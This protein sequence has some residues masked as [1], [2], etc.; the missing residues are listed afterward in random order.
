MTFLSL[1]NFLKLEFLNLILFNY[2]CSPQHLHS[3]T[4]FTKLIYKLKK[5][6]AKHEYY[7]PNKGKW[8]GGLGDKEHSKEKRYLLIFGLQL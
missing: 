6:Y 1:K 8:A 5:H 4:F 3:H 2:M 7:V